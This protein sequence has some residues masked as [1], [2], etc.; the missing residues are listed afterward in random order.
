MTK[1]S[2]LW[3]KCTRREIV[4]TTLYCNGFLLFHKFQRVVVRL[5]GLFYWSF[6]LTCVPVVYWRGLVGL[7][8]PRVGNLYVWVDFGSV[9]TLHPDL[10]Q[11]LGEQ[12]T[13]GCIAPSITT[14][15]SSPTLR[16]PSSEKQCLSL[17]IA[18]NKPPIG[19]HVRIRSS[20]T[21][22]W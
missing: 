4:W 17:T 21:L 9:T 20:S 12:G 1:E 6:V 7:R 10:M 19:G 15:H 2:N 8:P 5:Q 3:S 22:R 11:T 14:V 13:C 18:R 16:N